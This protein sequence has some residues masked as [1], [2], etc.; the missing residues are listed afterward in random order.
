MK[1]K[2]KSLMYLFLA[3]AGTFALLEF[4]LRVVDLAPSFEAGTQSFMAGAE[5]VLDKKY[6][7]RF[8][9]DTGRNINNYGFRDKDF[10]H[11]K[12][13]KKRVIFLGDSFIMA[14]NVAPEM[15]I[16]KLL[17][18]KL[19]EGFEVYNMGVH[20]YGPDQYL[21][22]FQEVALGFAP[23]MIIIGIFPSNDFNDIYKNELFVQKGSGAIAYNEDNAIK[24]YLPRFQTEYVLSHILVKNM[25]YSKN[26]VVG[27]YRE[28][29]FRLFKLLFADGYDHALEESPSSEA[30]KMKI[31]LFKGI[32]ERIYKQSRD[33][34][35][36]LFAIVIPYDKKIR[37]LSRPGATLDREAFPLENITN[38]ICR[39]IQL[40]CI[41][42]YEVFNRK[43]SK[44]K[45]Q[46]LYDS[47]D[48]HFSEFGNLVTTEIIYSHIME[49]YR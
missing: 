36:P 27:F 30:S 5:L 41:N 24:R 9:P 25:P 35:I 2:I 18:E 23:D 15:S 17:E 47:D 48:P 37:A 28:K 20:G 39:E 11:D 1:S 22:V 43:V 10:S 34:N 38:D 46:D 44:E 40:D 7:Y 13:Q 21:M 19:G 12:G 16:P 4:S 3:V 26:R 45:M 33:R 14:G 31:A 42:L 49:L 32:L 8:K 6:G 29:Y